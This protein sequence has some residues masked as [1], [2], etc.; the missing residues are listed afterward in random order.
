MVIKGG[1]NMENIN[2][3]LA[4]GLWAVSGLS[5]LMSIINYISFEYYLGMI[6]I[7]VALVFQGLLGYTILRDKNDKFTMISVILIAIFT[8]N[9]GGLV[10]IV[11]RLILRK[12]KESTKIRSAWFVPAIVAGAMA[13]INIISY[14]TLIGVVGLVLNVVYYLIFGYWFIKYLKVN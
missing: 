7:V 12:K 14:I 4:Y 11:M 1:I 8:F 13:L 3:K 2:K 10:A 6:G 5:A 9:L